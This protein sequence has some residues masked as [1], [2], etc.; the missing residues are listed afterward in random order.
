MLHE[1]HNL[2]LA[3]V[4][5][6]VYPSK[7]CNGNLNTSRQYTEIQK[8]VSNIYFMIED[9]RTNG[10]YLDIVAIHFTGFVIVLPLQKETNLPLQKGENKSQV[11]LV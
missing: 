2:I 10:K 1:A 5:L 4:W 9:H 6:E 11:C 8:P 3:P 7:Y